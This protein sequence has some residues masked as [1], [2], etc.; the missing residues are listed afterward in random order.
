MK[1]PAEPLIC[2]GALAEPAVSAAIA[3][4]NAERFLAEAIE[5]VLA[6][7]VPCLELIVVDN[8]STDATREVAERYARDGVRVFQETER[9]TARARNAALAV[10]RGDHLAFLDADD[11][12]E[13]HKNEV[14]LAALAPEDGPDVV[15]GHVVQFR[16][17]PGEHTPPQPGLMASSLASRGAWERVGSWPSEIGNTAE[18]LDWLLRVRRAGLREL[19]LDDVVLRRRIHGDNVGFRERETWG[20]MAHVVKRELDLRRAESR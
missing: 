15:F 19:M 6:Q 7:T 1:R 16:E 10:Y 11:L 20:E 18:G 13:P 2:W 5:S 3:A 4:R 14:Q 8:G 9:G 17:D 12:W